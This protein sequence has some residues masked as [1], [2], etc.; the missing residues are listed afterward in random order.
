MANPHDRYYELVLEKVANDRYPSGEL[1]DRIEAA[2][3]DRDQLD[4]Y[5][6]VLLDKIEIDRYPSKQMLDRVLRLATPSR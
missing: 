6:H 1:M 5:L 4:G 2:L 3:A